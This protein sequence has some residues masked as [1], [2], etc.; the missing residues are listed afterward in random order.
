M[1]VCGR[2]HFSHL[3]AWFRAFSGRA[4]PIHRRLGAQHPSRGLTRCSSRPPGAAT[5]RPQA[6]AR[7]R[8]NTSL[9][10]GKVFLL[11]WV[12]WRI[13]RSASS[14]RLQLLRP[15]ESSLHCFVSCRCR[16]VSASRCLRLL[17]PGRAFARPLRLGSA[18]GLSPVRIGADWLMGA[19]RS[20]AGLAQA[21]C[22]RS[23]LWSERVLPRP[24]PVSN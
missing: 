24:W 5:L 12:L 1:F 9:G 10:T 20:V 17:H 3:W 13:E 11:V 14:R 2:G 19:R 7:R 18:D 6:V 8:L 23:A 16:F 4:G 22:R 15:R 21:H